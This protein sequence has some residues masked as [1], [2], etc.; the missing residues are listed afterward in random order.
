MF[1]KIII[2]TLSVSVLY[3]S[4]SQASDRRLEKK[5]TNNM[6][7]VLKKHLRVAEIQADKLQK[8]FDLE[9]QMYSMI[10]SSLLSIDNQL[11]GDFDLSSILSYEKNRNKDRFSFDSLAQSK[12]GLE[13]VDYS[14]PDFSYESLNREFSAAAKLAEESYQFNKGYEE[15]R[16]SYIAGLKVSDNSKKST[17]KISEG[18]L[19]AQDQN[20]KMI[21]L[22]AGILK[23]L[24]IEQQD[25]QRSQQLTREFFHG[26]KL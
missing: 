25:K 2:L 4:F 7:G 26:K 13:I 8:Q 5:I 23:M 16:E 6:L 24:T 11:S 21:E 17:D 10:D 20:Q 15:N 22:N 12:D 19:I 9:K 1:R 3:G 14:T 18:L